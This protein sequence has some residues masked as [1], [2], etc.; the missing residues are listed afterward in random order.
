L[1]PAATL[2]CLPPVLITANIALFLEIKGEGL[3]RGIGEFRH[4]NDI[5]HHDS[6]R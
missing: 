4:T 3:D 1:S 2:Y 5:A 6:E